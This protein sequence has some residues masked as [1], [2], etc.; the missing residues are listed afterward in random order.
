MQEDIERLLLEAQTVRRTARRT[1]ARHAFVRPIQIFMGD[2]PA[3]RA[4]SKDISSVGISLIVE[5]LL[6]TGTIGLVQIHSI[7]GNPL[8]FRCELRWCDTLGKDWY[9]T[10]WKFLS[11]ATATTMFPTTA[12]AGSGIVAPA[13]MSMAPLSS[14]S[15]LSGRIGHP[16]DP[17][18]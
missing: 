4:F 17:G 2:R 18:L 11:E 12:A 3:I 14:S 9:L 7:H 16:A 8:C 15:P 10:G 13:N 5:H 1:E 6:E